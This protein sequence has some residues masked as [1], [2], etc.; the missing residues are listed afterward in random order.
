MG[1]GVKTNGTILMV[2]PTEAL[3]LIAAYLIFLL[4][5][6][7]FI[8]GIKI[9]A[10][11]D[12][13]KSPS[14]KDIDSEMILYPLYKWLT[15]HQYVPEYYVGDQLTVLIEKI[16]KAMGYDWKDSVIKVKINTGI[17]NLKASMKQV[18][19][20]VDSEIKYEI[21]DD[22]SISL[23]KL[24]KRYKYSKYIRKPIIQ[25]VVCMASFWGVFTYWPL[26][27]FVYGVNYFTFMLWIANTISLSYINFF[28]YKNHK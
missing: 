20:L 11:G 14:G 15:K 5:Q 4:L 13:V 27:Y 10:S 12:T 1:A 24:E 25:C 7:I 18:N 22:S 2:Q 21:N 9:S 8:N 3:A 6:A 28:I 26:I 16:N 23:Y 17:E 19:I